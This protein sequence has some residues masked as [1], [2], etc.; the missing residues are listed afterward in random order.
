MS[1]KSFILTIVGLVVLGALLNR[2]Y[3]AVGLAATLVA[4]GGYLLVTSRRTVNALAHFR[5]MPRRCQ[6]RA[7]ISVAVLLLML[8]AWFSGVI[9]YFMLLVLLAVD[10]MM[11]DNRSLNGGEKEKSR[12]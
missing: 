3:P 5:S 11:Y 4:L 9:S 2:D 8:S 10:Y 7:I 12:G 1:G 6:A